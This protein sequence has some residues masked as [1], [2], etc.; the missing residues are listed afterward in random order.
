MV[1]VVALVDWLESTS[2]STQIYNGEALTYEEA[3]QSAVQLE[4]RRFSPL[5][6]ARLRDAGTAQLLRRAMEEGRR[7]ALLQTRGPADPPAPALP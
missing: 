3:V 7:A 4:G 6:T 1:D 5:L 2:S